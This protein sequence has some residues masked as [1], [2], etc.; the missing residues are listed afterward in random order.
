MLLRSDIATL[1]S[2]RA[3]DFRLLMDKYPDLK[4]H[5]ESLSA[6][7]LKMNSKAQEAETEDPVVPQFKENSDNCR[8]AAVRTQDRSRIAATK[9]REKQVR[10]YRKK[11]EAE[12]SARCL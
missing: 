12:R 10:G 4:A 11:N 6:Q 1:L 2:L 5:V 7:R 8:G 9:A 3:Q